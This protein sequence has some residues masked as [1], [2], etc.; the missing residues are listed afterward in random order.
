MEH[1][2]IIDNVKNSIIQM[3]GVGNTL[4]LNE[5]DREII[6]ELEKKADEMTLMGLGR[7]DNKGVK[8]VLENDVIFA[9]TTNMDFCWPEGPNV[10]LMHDG[11]VVGQDI[12]DEAKL[13]EVKTCRDKLVIGNIVIYDT[14][15]LKK[16]DV[17]NNPLIVVLPPKSCDEVEAV[18]RA[19]NV[20]LA[21]PS[22]PSDE[23]LKEKMGLENLHGTGTFLLGFDFD[24]TCN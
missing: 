23:Y 9:F 20:I 10:I 11:C 15:V 5:N 17:K 6:R 13:E 24:D 7:G 16:M 14:S 3:Q 8:A 21:S 12:D 4:L 18:D 2:E 19:C 1:D 22:P